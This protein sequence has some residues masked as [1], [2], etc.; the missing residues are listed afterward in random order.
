MPTKKSSV[1]PT[2]RTAIKPSNNLVQQLK[3]NPKTASVIVALFILFALV[4]VIFARAAGTRKSVALTFN[5]PT[6]ANGTVSRQ[7]D[8][9]YAFANATSSSNCNPTRNRFTIVG[10]QIIDPSCKVFTPMGANIAISPGYVFNWKGVANGRVNEVKGWGW[11]MIRTNLTCLNANGTNDLNG[12]LSGLDSVVQEYTAQK[13]V[14]MIECHDYTGANRADGS[15]LYP[16]LD[17]VTTKYANN[18]Y[19]WFN[20]VN[21]PVQGSD[22]AALNTWTT[23]QTAMLNRVRAKAPHNI[24]VADIPGYGQAIDPVINGTSVTSLGSGKC[25]VMYSWHNYGA[26]SPNYNTNNAESTSFAYQQSAF[27]ALRTK[28]IPLLVGE[29]GDPL[30]LNEGTA[31][32][33]QWNRWGAYATM[34]YAPQNGVGILWWH[35]TRDSGVFLTYSLM[36]DRNVPLWSALP[37]GTGLSVGGQKFWALTHTAPSAL[38]FSG[39]I[40]QSNCN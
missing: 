32:S 14:V 40:N 30:T 38:P 22:T 23:L 33:P 15:A 4:I 5:N 35:A 13:I 27:E 29:I 12:M 25:N 7:G 8:G 24:Y 3:A 26:G 39:D 2:S 19:V 21:E 36:A 9:S 28:K 20:P 6:N 18:P 11:N 17:A 1:K 10:N 16:F 31:G 34:Q 37:N